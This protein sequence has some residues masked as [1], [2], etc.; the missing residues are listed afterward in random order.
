MELE[1]LVNLMDNGFSFKVI[2]YDKISV[3]DNPDQKFEKMRWVYD[4]IPK[5]LQKSILES[6]FEAK[7]FIYYGG[8]K[9]NLFTYYRS[10]SMIIDQFE[11]L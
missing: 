4:N 2:F 5:S 1:H 7:D 3:Y 10:R 6:L 11:W 9:D 8:C